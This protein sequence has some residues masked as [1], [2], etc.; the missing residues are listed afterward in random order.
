[1]FKIAIGTNSTYKVNAIKRAILD[2]DLE[3]EF[4]YDKV[5]SQIS[6]QPQ[7]VGETKLGSLNRA[8]N[9]LLEFPDSDF[10]IG[11]EFGYEPIDGRYFMACWASIVDNA[12]NHYSEQSSTLEL[13]HKLVEAI[14]KGIDVDSLL[15]DL[16]RDLHDTEVGRKYIEFLKKR[17]IIYE[18]VSNAVLRWYFSEDLY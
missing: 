7:Q 15:E 9:I 17:K 12:G 16:L 4:T 11:V 1:M 2:L 18:C 8:R 6:D 5:P 3:C 13:P 14:E 10:G